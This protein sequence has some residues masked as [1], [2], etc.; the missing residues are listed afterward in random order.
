MKQFFN[1]RSTS[2]Y[3]P[4]LKSE[5]ISHI[6]L[7]PLALWWLKRDSVSRLHRNYAPL[8]RISVASLHISL[9]TLADTRT[10]RFRFTVTLE[11]AHFL[12]KP[13]E[14]KGGCSPVSG[15]RTIRLCSSW[16][17]DDPP[18]PLRPS[19]DTGTEDRGG[20][21]AEFAVVAETVG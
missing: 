13:D 16:P 1:K 17:S 20:A 21:P 5:I 11:H 3:S 10:L 12:S 19:V 7:Q 9:H 15:V 18:T 2:H 8:T 6:F 14:N 4:F